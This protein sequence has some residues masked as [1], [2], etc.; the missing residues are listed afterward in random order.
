MPRAKGQ[1]QGSSPTPTLPSANFH[2][3]LG[4]WYPKVVIC[5]LDQLSLTIALHHRLAA[6]DQATEAASV[7]NGVT[8]TSSFCLCRSQRPPPCEGNASNPGAVNYKQVYPALQ[9]LQKQSLRYKNYKLQEQP[10][11]C[12]F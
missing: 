6:L 8:L 12:P 7:G 4:G 9:E 1:G 10:A 2:G 11:F 3:R 5:G